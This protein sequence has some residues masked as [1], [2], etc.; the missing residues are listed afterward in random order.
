MT[1][2]TKEKI[3]CEGGVDRREKDE[4]YRNK[5]FINEHTKEELQ[6][7]DAQ[8]EAGLGDHAEYNHVNCVSRG[9]SQKIMR[10]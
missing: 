10:L 2:S 6:S 7:W 9:S 5:T 1:H 4:E 3:K 8:M